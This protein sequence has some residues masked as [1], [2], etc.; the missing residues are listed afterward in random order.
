MRK[1]LLVFA[2]LL[3]ALPATA[4]AQ[5]D[6]HP[7]HDAIAANTASWAEAFNA[8]DAAG[9]AALYTEDA[10]II[11]PNMEPVSGNSG[12]QAFWAEMLTSGMTGEL[13]T[14]E[15]SGSGDML[16]E[17]GAFKL[18][19]ADGSHADH[20]VFMVVWTKVDG[21]WKMDRDIWN[22]SMP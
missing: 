19:N 17:V 8:G 11:P 22:S 3:M 18:T 9:I 12:I 5:H 6:H 13:K 7:E 21:Q 20:G 1:A 10:V 14:K 4:L 16:V 2:G 15:V